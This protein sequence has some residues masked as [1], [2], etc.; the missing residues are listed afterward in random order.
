MARYKVDQA[1][2]SDAAAIN[3]I[4][5]A[6]EPD[7][8]RQFMEGSG[9]AARKEAGMLKWWTKCLE[10]SDQRILVARDEEDGEIVSYAQW[11][12]PRSNA[13]NPTLAPQTA[14]VRGIIYILTVFFEFVI[15]F[16]EIIARKGSC[17]TQQC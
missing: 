11:D 5:C 3:K 9:D 14:E 6:A 7:P 16:R 8:F 2:P 10:S 17:Q 13:P 15:I 1:L 4:D 12:L